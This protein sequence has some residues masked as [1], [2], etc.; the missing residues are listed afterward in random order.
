MICA[1][2]IFCVKHEARHA[3]LEEAKVF[4]SE[5]MGFSSSPSND[6]GKEN[7]RH[8][9]TDGEEVTEKYRTISSN[10][11]MAGYSPERRARIAARAAEL[12]AEE[13]ALRNTR[14]AMGVNDFSD[15][16]LAALEAT[17]APEAAKAFDG[18]L[19]A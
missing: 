1:R 6:G 19:D 3:A 10:E 11:I 7:S 14:K 9:Y 17:R 5:F 16:D 18:E 8:P 12:I 15:A 13:F 2:H 4:D